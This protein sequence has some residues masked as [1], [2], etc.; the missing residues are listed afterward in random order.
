M[1]ETIECLECGAEITIE[2]ITQNGNVSEIIC[3]PLCGSQ[4][5]EIVDDE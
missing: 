5:I 3:C 4:D 2:Y 1:E